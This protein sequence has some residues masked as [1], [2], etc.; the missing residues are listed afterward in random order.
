MLKMCILTY[1]AEHRT[2]PSY[3]CDLIVT[4]VNTR[5]RRSNNYYLIKRCKPR[6]RSYGERCFKYAG[7]QESNNLPIHIR[8]SSS[9]SMFKAQLKT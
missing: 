2:A 1:Q 4:Y 8:K 6:L 3:L 7:P 5:S 9:L